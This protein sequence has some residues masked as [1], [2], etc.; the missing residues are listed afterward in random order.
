MP[1]SVSDRQTMRQRCF[2]AP[3]LPKRSRTMQS[4]ANGLFS[5]YAIPRERLLCLMVLRSRGM[6]LPVKP[7][8]TMPPRLEHS[9][10]RRGERSAVFSDFP[11]RL[12]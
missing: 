5:K 1:I 12:R 8:A 9:L 6:A 4:I 11:A 3:A 7:R 2:E 10:K